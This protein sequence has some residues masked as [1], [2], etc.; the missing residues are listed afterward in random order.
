MIKAFLHYSKSTSNLPKVFYRTCTH[1][2]RRKR[3]K[4]FFTYY[5]NTLIGR[6][7]S[8]SRWFSYLR[9]RTWSNEYHK[10][11]RKTKRQNKAGFLITLPGHCNHSEVCLKGTVP[12][13]FRLLVFFHESVSPKPLSIPLGPFWIFWHRWQI[14]KQ[15]QQHQ[16]YKWQNLPPVS[17]IPVVH[18]DLR[19]ISANFL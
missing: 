11:R 10:K 2:I 19:K 17:L 1:R 6:N 14:C 13:D 12:R 3:I 7:L 9:S 15:Y 16:L 4:S 18:L 8:H 5:F